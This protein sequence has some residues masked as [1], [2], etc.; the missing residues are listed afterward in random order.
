[1]PFSNLTLMRETR[2]I[3]G[4]HW[5]LGVLVS[6]VFVLIVG[7]PSGVFPGTGELVPLLLSGPL[8]LGFALFSLSVVR[9]DHPHFNQL[10]EG[11]QGFVKSFLAY[12]CMMILIG[13]GFVLLIIPGIYIWLALSMTFLVM[14]DRPELSFSE[15]LNESWKI[16][17][18]YKLKFLGLTIRFIP[19]YILGI[20]CLGVGVLLVI[21]WHQA[22]I[23]R[24][25]EEIK[26]ARTN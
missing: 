5:G 4:P 6:F 12:L 11:F 13:V 8:S 10:F 16:T 2:D 24:F 14:A 26:T 21:P 1:M 17:D 18:G 15:C 20:L 9:G 19:W 25:Y 23:A 22:T 7:A 3:F